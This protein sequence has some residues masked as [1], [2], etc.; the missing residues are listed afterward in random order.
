MLPVN[1][2]LFRDGMHVGIVK[3]NH[4]VLQ[5]VKIGRDYGKTVEIVSG[6]SDGDMVVINPPDSLQ[7]KQEVHIVEQPKDEQSNNGSNSQSQKNTSQPKKDDTGS[8]SST[9]DDN[10]AADPKTGQQVDGQKLNSQSNGKQDNQAPTE[11]K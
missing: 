5:P 1:T 9:S 8:P 11:T 10:K 4:I 2:L 7:D 6:V 3:D